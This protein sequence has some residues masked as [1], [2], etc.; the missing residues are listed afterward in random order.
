MIS[1]R[2]PPTT[3]CSP[4]T[5][6]R[7]SRCGCSIP[8]P[9][10][11]SACSAWSPTSP[12]STSGCTTSRSLPTVRSPSSAAAISA[13]NIIG[14]H[15]GANFADLD[16]A[17]IGPVV[18]E[19]SDQFDLYWNHRAAV[20]I[21]A[22]SRQDTTPE[23]FA[24]KRA[25]LVAHRDT[26]EAL[27]TMRTAVRDSEFARQLRNRR[28]YVLLGTGHDRERSSRQGAHLLREDGDAS[29]P[30]ASRGRRITRSASCSSSRLTSCRGRRASRC[31]PA[32][33]SAARAWS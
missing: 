20:P 10:V 33:A 31:W 4:S 12:A 9:C 29:R 32:C 15:A 27:R 25:A 18:K 26:A 2:C 16:V 23:Q 13:M 22:L 28:G 3:S 14:A 5:A 8:W 6:I 24:Q 19:V 7:T 30:T 21:A 17:V 11:R 1:A